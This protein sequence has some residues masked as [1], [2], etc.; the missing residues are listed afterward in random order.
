VS[1]RKTR[2]RPVLAAV[3]GPEYED[4]MLVVV[5]AYAAT[6][7]QSEHDIDEALRQLPAIR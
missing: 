4:N 1:Q 3:T 2:L 5:A 6:L 7:A